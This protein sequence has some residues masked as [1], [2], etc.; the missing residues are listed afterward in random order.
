VGRVSPGDEMGVK[1]CIFIKERTM[2]DLN[3]AHLG[4]EEERGGEGVMGDQ[5]ER[6]A[7]CRPAFLHFRQLSVYTTQSLP[8]LPHTPSAPLSAQ[9]HTPHSSQTDVSPSHLQSSHFTHSFINFVGIYDSSLWGRACKRRVHRQ[10][11]L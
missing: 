7:S 11:F 6:A 4:G 10:S 5:T 3:R 8:E 9:V 1:E 2:H